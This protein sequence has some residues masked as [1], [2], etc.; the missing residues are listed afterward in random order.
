M[1]QKPGVQCATRKSVGIRIRIR[2]PVPGM[3]VARFVI[4]NSLVKPESFESRKSETRKGEKEL[5]EDN[6][7]Y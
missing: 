4:D 3:R 5:F 1:Q 7:A 2:P 6:P